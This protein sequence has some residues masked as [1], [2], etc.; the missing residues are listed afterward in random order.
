MHLRSRNNEIFSITTTAVLWLL[1]GFCTIVPS[2]ASLDPSASVTIN[3][4]PGFEYQRTC[5]SG[6]LQN[7][8]DGGADI[9]KVLGC[10][11]NGCYCGTQYQAEA[12]SIVTSCWSAY[13]GTSELSLLGYDIS[14]ALSLYNAYCGQSGGGSSASTPSGSST[15]YL[16]AITGGAC[17][18]HIWMALISYLPD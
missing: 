12:S 1:L 4:Y 14:T 15:T 11:W 17:D 13:C 7:N 3:Q 2:Y 5:G 18:R 10:T 16:S 9:Q 6:C 8:Y